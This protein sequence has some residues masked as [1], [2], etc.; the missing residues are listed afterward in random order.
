MKEKTLILT[1]SAVLLALLII[2]QAVT[3]PL[4]QLVTGSCVNLVL[5]AAALLG[6]VW[7][8]LFVALLSPV[9]AFLLGIGPAL[10]QLV[11]AICTANA[12]FTTVLWIF[13]RRGG[14]LSPGRAELLRYAGVAAGA[15]IKLLVIY[16][17]AVVLILPS[18]GLPEKQA[19]AITVMFSWTQLLTA[20]AGGALGS[21]ICGLISRR[22]G[23]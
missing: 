10:V 16:V 18:L 15:A 17:L 22:S 3:K 19:A 2:L 21:V 23:S 6:G 20:L 1:R 8:G 9:F 7:C 13:S 14:T 5:T 4:G 11:P 12:A